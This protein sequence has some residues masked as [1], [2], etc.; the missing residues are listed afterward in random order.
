MPILSENLR[1]PLTPQAIACVE[2]ADACPEAQA[3][4]ERAENRFQALLNVFK[5]F[6]HNPE[7]GNVF[8]ETVMAILKDGALP[9]RTKELLILKTTFESSCRYCVTQHER[10]AE[11][12]GIAPETVAELADDGYLTSTV[13]SEAERALI[14]YAGQVCR[15][16]NDVPPKLW[17]TLKRH[18]T[19]AQLVEATFVISFYVAVSKFADSL[20]LELEPQFLSEKQLVPAA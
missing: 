2:P 3:F 18:W 1:R 8:T 12:V 4:F 17:R 6:G 10:V 9:W 13:L 5:V 7:F 20:G 14:A 15:D 16:A 11:M 19:D